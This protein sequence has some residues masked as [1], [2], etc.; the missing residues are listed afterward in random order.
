MWHV[1]V[2]RIYARLLYCVLEGS[3][4][5]Q[6]WERTEVDLEEEEAE[7]DDGAEE[8]EPDVTA[9]EED[10]VSNQFSQRLLTLPRSLRSSIYE[11]IPHAE[12][13]WRLVCSTPSDTAV[14][15]R[16]DTGELSLLALREPGRGRRAN[17]VD[18]AVS[19]P[20]RD[21]TSECR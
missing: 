15:G 6:A 9:G 10:E 18:R 16:S 3:F 20:G 1:A 5:Y 12:V 19:D 21:Q 8:E 13:H 4:Q 2:A 7:D 17:A 11:T 14:C